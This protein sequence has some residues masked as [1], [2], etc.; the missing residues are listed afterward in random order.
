L[1]RYSC[2]GLAK[3]PR[4]S[5]L[6]GPTLGWARQKQ[7]LCGVGSARS[8]A[9]L[10]YVTLSSWSG[11][12]RVIGKAE[13]TAQGDTPRF[14]LTNLPAEGFA[15]DPSESAG[16]LEAAPLY[17]DLYCGRGERKNNLKERQLDL[18]ATRMSTTGWPVIGSGS[19]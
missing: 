19:G 11:A 3:N 14:V 5:T 13:V 7:I 4:L 10:T 15:G 8:F 1:V 2:L 12:R 6:L 9:E 16:R 18:Q 17:E